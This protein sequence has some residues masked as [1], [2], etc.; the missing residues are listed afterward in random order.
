M[1]RMRSDANKMRAVLG[2]GFL[3]R[4]FYVLFSTIYDRQYD[5]GMIDLDAGHPVTGGHLAYIQYLYENWR[6]P[7]FDPTSVYQFNHPPLHHYISALWLKL[8]SFFLRDT[9]VLEESLQAVP[10]LC[11][12]LILLVLLK[13]LRLLSLQERTRRFLMLLFSF[14]PTLVLLS[15]S[16]NNDCM[17]LLFTLLCVYTAIVWGRA[18]GYRRILYLAL[19]IALGMLTKQN[20]AEMALPIG[21]VFLYVLIAAWKK[22]GFPKKL[23]GQFALFGAVS[24]PLGMCFYV[25]NMLQFHMPLV[26]IYELPKD[27]WQYTG[28]VPLVNRLLWPIPQEMADNL[29]HFRIG[30]GY[31]VWM[32]IIRT[33]VLGEWDM[34]G[35]GY[36]VKALAV[37]LMF[38]GAAL[39]GAS[40]IAF[41][42]VF[43]LPSKKYAV[44]TVCRIVF[45]AGYFVNLVGYLLFVYRYP[46][47]CSMHFRYIE[48]ELLFPAAA[49]GF[50][51]QETQRKWLRLT[52]D[53]LLA[54][55]CALSVAMTCVWCLG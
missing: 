35:V 47:E 6:L 3:L 18:P 50:V 9:A 38:T 21:L 34:A 31:N 44:D 49:L 39:G 27:S 54:A 8:A 11:S 51:W 5:I 24:I 7:D 48:I 12:L 46:Q 41:F 33:S 37:L 42:R 52:L 30:C 28:N 45:V 29:L 32:Q 10:F 16:V 43:C 22:E 14:H 1:E 20:V 36:G 17:S 23:L 15:G 25:R 40:L 4:L 53:A 2:A 13:I 26:W 19:S 55:F